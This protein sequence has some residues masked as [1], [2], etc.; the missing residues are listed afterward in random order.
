MNQSPIIAALTAINS[1][2][3]SFGNCYWAFTYTDHQTGKTV[4]GTVSGGES[5][6]RSIM[7]EL[8]GGNWEPRNVAFNTRELPIRE[9]NRLTKGWSYAGCTGT[10]LVAFIRRELAK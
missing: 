10:E 7:H 1:R 3:D 2:R 4:Q 9:F 6:V 5:N 8:N